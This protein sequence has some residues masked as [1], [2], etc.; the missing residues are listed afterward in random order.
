MKS[1]KPPIP[2]MAH[3]FTFL[4]DTPQKRTC[5]SLVFYP[6][7]KVPPLSVSCKHRVILSVEMSLIR[8]YWRRNRPPPIYAKWCVEPPPYQRMGAYNICFRLRA[9]ALLLAFL[10]LRRNGLYELEEF[11]GGVIC[12]ANLCHIFRSDSAYITEEVSNFAK[13]CLNGTLAF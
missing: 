6:Y 11:I 1:N 7:L 12:L 9:L 10:V 3:C 4:T 13:P 5:H 8:H 2:T